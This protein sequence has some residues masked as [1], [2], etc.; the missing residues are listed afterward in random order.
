MDTPL[1]AVLELVNQLSEQEREQV[2]E[3][4]LAK[5]SV[6]AVPVSANQPDHSELQRR[7]EQW[8]EEVKTLEYEQPIERSGL[9]K[10]YEDL[11]VE[12]YRQQGLKL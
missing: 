9:K 10:E 8:T 5:R 2:T 11:L 12:K 4:L 7:L 6:N 3:Y 1:A